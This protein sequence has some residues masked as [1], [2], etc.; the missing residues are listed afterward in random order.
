MIRKVLFWTHLSMGVA[1]GLVIALMGVTGVLLT[2]EL[3]L[4]RLADHQYRAAPPPDAAMLPL[5]TL[6]AT[7]AEAGA[8][9]GRL[10][11]RRDSAD[12]V[13]VSAGRRDPGLYLDAYSG[14]VLGPPSAAAR[15]LI[16]SLRGLHRWLLVEGDQRGTARLVTGISNLVFLLLI[17]TGLYLWLPRL[18]RWPL[19][20][21]R[22]LFSGPYRDTRSRD[23]HWH[24]VF[25]IWAALPLLIITATALV[26]SFSWANG[27]VYAAFGESPPVRGASGGGEVRVETAAPMSGVPL[28][29][30]VAAAVAPYPDWRRVIVHEPNGES[31]D[32]RIEVDAGNGRQPHRVTT[33]YL[34]RVTGAVE[35]VAYFQDRTPGRQARSW[36][37]FLH[38]GEAFGWPGQTLAGIASVVSLIMVWTGLAL[39]WRRLIRPM[40]QRRGTP[41][42]TAD[43]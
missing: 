30:L 11:L 36:I 12:P 43:S 31:A 21:P 22:L 37:R 13:L 7:A 5:E 24:H 9:P 32:L 1:A 4:L 19:L 40:L 39:A 16:S 33:V 26:F 29:E 41:G 3:Q 20:K 17:A 18:L 10:T 38:T 8:E 28:A 23:Y 25:G 27:L 42:M 6:L 34:S 2:Y 15:E 14:A 35:R